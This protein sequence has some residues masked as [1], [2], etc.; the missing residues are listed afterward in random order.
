MFSGLSDDLSSSPE[1]IDVMLKLDVDR[2]RELGKSNGRL[3]N[4]GRGVRQRLAM[5][6]N[7]SDR[8]QN[9]YCEDGLS[10]TCTYSTSRETARV[11]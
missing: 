10:R 7:C 8:L 11:L 4:S 2:R 5:A 6:K 1:L 9:A 3:G